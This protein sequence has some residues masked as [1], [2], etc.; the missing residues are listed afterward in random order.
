VVVL[1]VVEVV[2]KVVLEGNGRRPAVPYAIF[3]V[4]S[5]WI[6]PIDI[7]VVPERKGGIFRYGVSWL[8]E[9]RTGGWK[10]FVREF[11]GAAVE[12]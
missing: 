12:A 11:V 9:V 10:T 1:R 4:D 2:T 3:V 5:L 8:R 7:S 6:A